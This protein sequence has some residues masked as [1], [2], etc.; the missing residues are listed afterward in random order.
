[1]TNSGV[2]AFIFSLM[3]VTLLCFFYFT[4]MAFCV[5]PGQGLHSVPAGIR[6]SHPSDRRPSHPS[7]LGGHHGSQLF[8]EEPSS[9]HLP[10]PQ[11]AGITQLLPVPKQHSKLQRCQRPGKANVTG[12]KPRATEATTEHNIWTDSA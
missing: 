6:P 2:S 3:A 1:M 12:E 4:A 5:Q 8:N 10:E 9:I 7:P 11:A